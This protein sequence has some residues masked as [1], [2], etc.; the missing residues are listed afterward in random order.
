[1]LHRYLEAT[2][3]WANYDEPDLESR[4][5]GQ[6]GKCHCFLGN[7]TEAVEYFTRQLE[8]AE[9]TE[10]R[11]YNLAIARYNMAFAHVYLNAPSQARDH[12]ELAREHLGSLDPEVKAP[13]LCLRTLIWSLSGVVHQMEGNF[14][15]AIPLHEE[16]LKCAERSGDSI[17]LH[18]IL[19][20]QGICLLNLDRSLDAMPVLERSLAVAR[21]VVDPLSEDEEKPKEEEKK[22][23]ELEGPEEEEAETDYIDPDELAPLGSAATRSEMIWRSLYNVAFSYFKQS[24]I[25][26]ALECLREAEELA[27]SGEAA[28]APFFY[29]CSDSLPPGYLIP[30]VPVGKIPHIGISP[31][32]PAGNDGS[33]TSASDAPFVESK[34]NVAIRAQM[35][36]LASTCHMQ[37]RHS[38]DGAPMPNCDAAH[39]RLAAALAVLTES[40]GNLDLMRAQILTMHA[41]VHIVKGAGKSASKCLTEASELVEKG[42]PSGSESR[43]V[44]PAQASDATP[45]E[46]DPANS[47]PAIQSLQPGTVSGPKRAPSQRGLSSGLKR[48]LS[49]AGLGGVGLGLMLC[50]PLDAKEGSRPTQKQG[51][52]AL[53]KLEEA[54][55]MAAKNKD[56]PALAMIS[57]RM[58]YA[59]FVM[60]LKPDAI[61]CFEQEL[62]FARLAENLGAQAIAFRSLADAHSLSGDE[63]TSLSHLKSYLKTAKEAGATPLEADAC[64]RLTAAYTALA[65]EKVTGAESQALSEEELNAMAE[66]DINEREEE[67]KIFLVANAKLR[68][69]AFQKRYGDI[70]N[71]WC[72]IPKGSAPGKPGSAALGEE[73]KS[74]LGTLDEVQELGGGMSALAG[75][76]KKGGFAGLLL[77]K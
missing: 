50:P 1:M 42:L 15:D 6:A 74:S 2:K 66:D 76:S 35:M 13:D 25:P 20:N 21:K 45:P 29:F 4:A 58:G 33:E 26:D 34:A 14:E 17:A 54:N 67:D 46:A 23:P 3:A 8:L 28:T 47:A 70:C 57:G 36:A 22:K 77:K 56:L 7:L 39:D 31:P 40:Q 5:A 65:N 18:Q 9:K 62:H 71:V 75:G 55:E 44:T 43:A 48:N 69:M 30:A 53:E 38:D 60:G 41:T 16:S 19:S 72:R 37:Q 24:K 52:T 32:E 51:R 10:K 73:A 12:L 49:A 64:K 61:E 27:A 59:K 68:A 63:R 11:E